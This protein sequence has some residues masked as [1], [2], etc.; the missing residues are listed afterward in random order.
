MVC[1][2]VCSGNGV[3]VVGRCVCASGWK[4]DD[5]A[6]VMSACDVPDC[7]EHGRCNSDG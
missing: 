2:Q 6:Q 3:F 5:C 7:N 4:G 1:A